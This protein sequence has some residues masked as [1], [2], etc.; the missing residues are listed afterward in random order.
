MQ[1]GFALG[2]ERG[3]HVELV[4]TSARPG[5]RCR[6]LPVSM[7]DLVDQVVAERQ[8]G[9][10]FDAAASFSAPKTSNS[11]QTSSMLFSSSTM[12]CRVAAV[13]GLELVQIEPFE[14]LLVDPQLQVGHDRAE[15]GFQLA[16]ADDVAVSRPRRSA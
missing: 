3:R 11:R 9:D 7:I 12:L 16:A 14:Q 8:A 4:V 15:V 1:L 5:R 10:F 6:P 2:H 13:A